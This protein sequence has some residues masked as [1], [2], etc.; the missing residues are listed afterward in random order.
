M[1]SYALKLLVLA[2]FSVGA[3]F[4]EPFAVRAD[5]CP[6]TP[7][8]SFTDTDGHWA[9]L[10]VDWVGP[11]CDV[12][13]YR[14]ENGDS[15]HLFRPDA[16]ITR[17]EFLTMLTRCRQLNVGANA[18][19]SFPDV[20]LSDWFSYPVYIG[21]SHGIISGYPDGKFRPHQAVTRA[22]AALMV[23]RSLG[24]EDYEMKTLRTFEDVPLNSWF[25]GA[26]TRL[27]DVGSMGPYGGS[28]TLFRPDLPM[29]RAETAKIIAR[30]IPEFRYEPLSSFQQCR[31]PDSHRSPSPKL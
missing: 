4:F 3:F 19:V 17:A 21:V 25:F 30:S 16:S 29:T 7:D 9:A 1:H 6:L 10:Y 31:Y 14:D 15:L 24:L 12:E 28:G 22:E 8:T 26:V 27:T 18:T 20:Y 13:G 2:T 23:H 11:N 5:Q